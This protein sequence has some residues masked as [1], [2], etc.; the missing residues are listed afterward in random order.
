MT[1]PDSVTHVGDSAFA[2][3]RGLTTVKIGKGLKEIGKDAFNYCLNI[4]SVYYADMESL[5]NMKG[6][7]NLTSGRDKQIYIS[8]NLF[9]DF[10]FAGNIENVPDYAF[11][12]C[13]NILS[14]TMRGG[15]KIG[16][17]AFNDCNSL[18]RVTIEN[19]ER[20]GK[21]AFEYCGNLTS[22]TIGEGVKII[23][24]YAFNGCYNI[25]E[26]VIPE[27]VQEIGNR[28]FYGCKNLKKLTIKNSKCT[29]NKDAFGAS[30][31]KI[32]DVPAEFIEYFDSSKL[33]ELNIISGETI[34]DNALYGCKTLKKITILSSVKNIGKYGFMYCD[35]LDTIVADKDNATYYSKN[36]CLIEKTTQ[37]LMLGC[38]SSVIPAEVKSI[39]DYA[40]CGASGLTR[41]TFPEGLES[42]GEHAFAECKNLNNPIIPSGVKNIGEYAFAWCFSI[43][44]VTIPDG[45]DKISKGLFYSCDSLVGVTIPQS[46]T[47]IDADAFK[48]CEKLAKIDFK[49]TTAE[50]NKITKGNN[51]NLKVSSN[52]KVNCLGD[53]DA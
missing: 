50:W 12:N 48:Y 49:G 52:F 6:L 42:I 26:I 36:N 44:D 19:V 8:G 34:S 25:E 46:V 40:F 27:S 1:I 24:D 32:A 33:Q 16:E 53:A 51:W 13:G 43:T 4:K 29:I 41:I 21:S 7:N 10:I 23:E 47:A 37:K 45:V 2:A 38:Q 30:E 35:N 28:A 5:C 22:L 39:G 15:K 18:E 9:T 31:M 20:I 11:Y 3:C 14:F 17:S